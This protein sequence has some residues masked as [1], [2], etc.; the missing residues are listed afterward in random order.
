MTKNEYM[1]YER[2]V[3]D[4]M[5]REGIENLTAGHFSCPDCNVEFNDNDKCVKCGG[6]QAVFNEPFFSWVA[7]DCCGD[8]TGGNREFATG[9][10]PVENKVRSYNLCEDCVYYSEYGRLDDKSMIATESQ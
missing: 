7:C 3:A 10:N 2:S 5:R 6:D 4:F 9:Y 1:Q 8:S